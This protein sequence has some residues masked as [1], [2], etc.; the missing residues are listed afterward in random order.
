MKPVA[1]A[2]LLGA[3]TAANAALAHHPF[4]SEFD[5]NAPLQLSGKVMKVDWNDPH[6]TVHLVVADTGGQTR[7]WS[8][9][10]A[11]PSMMQ[12]KGWQKNTL[13]EGEQI[14]IQGYRA[15]SEPFTAAAR[16]IVLSNGK[17]MSSADDDDDGPKI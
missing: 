6:V 16:V 10:A 9:E 13:K 4:A 5:A 2:V 14:T 3:L 1:V 8:F 12:K 15:K 7:E 11:S 17:S